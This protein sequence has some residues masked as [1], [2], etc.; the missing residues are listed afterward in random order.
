MRESIKKEIWNILRLKNITFAM[1]YKESGDII[2]QQGRETRCNN[3]KNGSYF[4]RELIHKTWEQPDILDSYGTGDHINLLNTFSVSPPDPHIKCIVI[5]NIKSRH[6]YFFYLESPKQEYFTYRETE[7]FSH[8]AALLSEVLEAETWKNEYTHS[9]SVSGGSNAINAVK[10]RVLMYA[11]E[12]EPI[13]LLGETGV[14][15]NHIAKLI[16]HLS[17]RSG[18]FVQV[19]IPSIPET[20]FESEVFGHKKGAFTGANEDRSGLVDFARDGTLFFDEISEVPLTFQAKLL[21]FLDTW[22]FR[23]LGESHERESDV[24]IIAATNKNLAEEIDDKRFR[25]DLYYR[26]NVLPIEIPPLRER[27]EDIKEIIRAEMHYLRGKKVSEGFWKEV[28][29]YDWPGNIRELIHVLK[30]TGI[31]LE[32]PIKAA[33][34]RGLIHYSQSNARQKKNLDVPAKIL[35]DLEEGKTFW[36]IVKEPFLNRD[37]NREQVRAVISQAQMKMGGKYKD[38]LNLFGIQEKE[39]KNFMNFL[40]D[41]DLK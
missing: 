39:Y 38:L 12:T 30:R 18:Q 23:R 5:L 13:L 33:D 15:K 20:L 4:A 28:S 34:I 7:I 16:H 9:I 8:L 19:H 31:E 35:N 32:S 37:L 1:L 25:K 21:Q 3:V 2:W 29:D 26:L 11:V 10:T 22:K 27:K 40:Y 41:N 24:R 6:H 17:G 36:K 14:G